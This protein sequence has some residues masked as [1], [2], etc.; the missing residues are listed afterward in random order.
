MLSDGA[1]N[2]VSAGIGAHWHAWKVDYAFVPKGDLGLSH[3][4]TLGIGFGQH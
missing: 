1:P 4:V 3:F 2:V